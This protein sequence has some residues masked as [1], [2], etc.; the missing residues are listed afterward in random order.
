[1]I[2]SVPLLMKIV[3][4]FEVK[5]I[6]SMERSWIVIITQIFIKH[7]ITM[8]VH[9]FGKEVVIIIMMIMNKRMD[10]IKKIIT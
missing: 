1:M 2:Q 4:K 6:M 8:N 10:I 7:S 3:T 5:I 9:G